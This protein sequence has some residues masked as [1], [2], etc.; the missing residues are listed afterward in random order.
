M[1]GHLETAGHHVHLKDLVG[2]GDRIMALAAPF[3]VVGLAANLLW[4]SVFRMG[5]GAAAPLLGGILLTIGVPLWLGSAVQV[6]VSVPKGRL[7]TTGPFALMLH[8]LYTSV[9]LLVIPGCGLFFDSWL[10]FVL[11]LV[12]YVASRRYAPSEERELAERFG[13]D[14]AEY[15]RHVLLPWL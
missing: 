5:L 14:Y 15:R 13:E 6:L 11:G 7:I 2:A 1:S 10:G 12:L 3:A 4:P 9:A 8:P